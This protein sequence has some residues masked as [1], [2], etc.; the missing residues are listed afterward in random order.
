MSLFDNFGA[1]AVVISYGGDHIK[2]ISVDNKD[3]VQK[4]PFVKE[5]YAVSVSRAQ[6]DNNL[7][8]ILE[9][10]LNCNEIKLVLISNWQVTKYGRQLY[11]KYVNK[12]N[13]IL[14]NAIYESTELDFIRGNAYLYIHSHARCGTAPSL[15][16]AMNLKLPVLSFDVPI[17]REI[18]RNN[19][20]Y[21]SNSEDLI[22]SLYQ[23]KNQ[24]I[25][26]NRNNMY[27][28][29]SKYYTWDIVSNA[30]SKVIEKL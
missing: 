26:Q 28:I 21:F 25:K 30:Y 12:R 4:Y 8:I 13:I 2:Y 23:L 29:A 20:T 7:H 10:F 17:N 3:L 15:I 22:N 14:L 27:S 18:T 1:K 5:K 19:A 9:A 6:I 11:E 24:E 16:E